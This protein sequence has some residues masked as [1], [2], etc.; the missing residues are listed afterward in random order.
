MRFSDAYCSLPPS[1]MDRTVQRSQV[2]DIHGP[3]EALPAPAG[4]LIAVAALVAAAAA[5][6]LRRLAAQCSAATAWN[7][8]SCAT[9]S[10]WRMP[11]RRVP[12]PRRAAGRSPSTASHR[13]ALPRHRP[14]VPRT[15]PSTASR[16]IGFGSAADAGRR[17][18]IRPTAARRQ[19]QH[20]VGSAAPADRG[21]R[22][23]QGLP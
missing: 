12:P 14:D 1:I 11:T 23:A 7:A 18:G 3:F 6:I 10:R 2:G 20:R 17:S 15:R 13:R 9:R 4:G 5:T 16:C 8:D 19:H 22:A 21:Q